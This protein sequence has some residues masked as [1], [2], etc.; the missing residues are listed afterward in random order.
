MFKK[1]LLFFLFFFFLTCVDGKTP[2]EQKKIDA[3]KKAKENI[4]LFL[5]INKVF[6]INYYNRE[7]LYYLVYTKRKHYI[8]F[9][10]SIMKKNEFEMF[11]LELIE[12]KNEKDNTKP[13]TDTRRD[14]INKP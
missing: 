1:R 14:D 8:F 10:Q 3:E 7:N 11:T 12:E 6:K 5:D 2:Y 9:R 4:E 13:N